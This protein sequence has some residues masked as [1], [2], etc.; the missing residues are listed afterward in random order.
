MTD[1]RSP[2]DW[3]DAYAE[4]KPLYE[5]FAER[6]DE[7][8]RNLL[9]DAGID[10][11]ESVWWTKYVD[12]FV[13]TIYVRGREGTPV[14]DPF[15]DLPD[16]CGVT[17][18]THT[19]AE[20]ES[21]CELVES[22]FEV[23]DGTLS[24]AAAELS[25]TDPAAGG[26]PGRVTYD[27]PHIVV[28][29]PD[30]R[31][32]LSEW[33]NFDGLRAEIRV[34]TLLQD[35]WQKID[36]QVLPFFWD[37]SY[38]EDVRAAI[39]RA[40]GLVAAAD[41]ELSR[42][43]EATEDA[44]VAYAHALELG[45]DVPLDLSALYVYLRDSSIVARLVAEAEAAGMTHDPDPVRVSEATLWLVRQCGFDSLRE[46]DAFLA[47]SEPRARGVLE[48]LSELTRAEDEFQ[49]WAETGSVVSWLLLVLTRADTD[50]VALTTF[51]QSIKTA[52]DT[53]IGNRADR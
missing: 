53:L 41:E 15:T 48:R 52:V 50:V 6:L 4:R 44:E 3:G 16:L 10:Y 14:H 27:T 47:A 30:R 34:Q 38:P 18:V 36:E 21:I 11:V 42:I 8:L 5:S 40:V 37:S 20:S 19:K 9:Q 7:L 22:E 28:S 43:S 2:D 31:M 29:L 32:E 23:Q 24:F 12:N 49:P 13:E 1:A 33:R 46:L 39:V 45:D 26:S 17:F 35:A 25:N 51:R